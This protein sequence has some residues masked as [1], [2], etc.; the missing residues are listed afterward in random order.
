MG[1]GGS[2]VSDGGGVAES[3]TG[4]R[5][6]RVS[7]GKGGS[8]VSDVGKQGCGVSNGERDSRVTDG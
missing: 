1:E 4:R 5:G 3:V 2:R 8:R 6:S 7:G